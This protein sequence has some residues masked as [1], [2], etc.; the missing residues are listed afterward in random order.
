M[1]RYSKAFHAAITNR[2]IIIDNKYSSRTY[3][4]STSVGSM[5]VVNLPF[6]LVSRSEVLE[7]A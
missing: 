2:T 1:T 7:V 5:E 4:H 6:I 3:H